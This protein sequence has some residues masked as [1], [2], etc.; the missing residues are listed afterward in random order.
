[1]ADAE[2]KAKKCTYKFKKSKKG[3]KSAAIENSKFCAAH[4]PQK[5][6]DTNTVPEM[7]QSEAESSTLAQQEQIAALDGESKLEAPE[8]PANW[9][10]PVAQ[11]DVTAT[12]TEYQPDDDAAKRLADAFASM[13]QQMLDAAHQQ[14]EAAPQEEQYPEPI[15]E[16]YNDQENPEGQ[17]L[18]FFV[19]TPE[20]M[21]NPA[22]AATF[23][24]AFAYQDA[25]ELDTEPRIVELLD[26]AQQPD[27]NVG[28]PSDAVDEDD[29]IVEDAEPARQE[30]QPVFRTVNEKLAK[31][32]RKV[33]VDENEQ[34]EQDEDQDVPNEP[35]FKKTKAKQSKKPKMAQCDTDNESDELNFRPSKK[36]DSR[37]ASKP[38]KKP[39]DSPQRRTPQEPSPKTPNAPRRVTFHPSEDAIEDKHTPAWSKLLPSKNKKRGRNPAQH[40]IGTRSDSVLEDMDRDKVY[41][42]CSIS[43]YIAIELGRYIDTCPDYQDILNVLASSDGLLVMNK[44]TT[45]QWTT[46]KEYA[47][48]WFHLGT[49]QSPVMSIKVASKALLQ[50]KKRVSFWDEAA[51]QLS[52][53]WHPRQHQFY[54]FAVSYKEHHFSVAPFLANP[55][56]FDPN[57]TRLDRYLVAFTQPKDAVRLANSLD[58]HYRPE[59]IVLRVSE[60]SPFLPLSS[61]QIALVPGTPLIWC[62]APDPLARK[63]FAS[64]S[65]VVAPHVRVAYVEL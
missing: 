24:T 13:K 60:E 29:A 17:S 61:H 14:N 32:S 54:C 28:S 5:E 38:S 2:V 53:S 22:F 62:G 45:S 27:D 49:S 34:D 48:R 37:T 16:D 55:K 25:E 58:P 12:D 31:K 7:S 35:V 1:M 63:I 10:V 3:C 57:V 51:K 8:D 39:K 56:S 59:L 33:I 19:V 46:L 65:P 11:P 4:A 36:V 23:G 18:P 15:E 6:A 50:L 21:A 44:F 47:G 52:Q 40:D 26:D 20:M 64:E 41:A 30:F 43:E 9:Q 42:R